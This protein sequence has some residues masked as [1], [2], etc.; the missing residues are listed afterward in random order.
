MAKQKRFLSAKFSVDFRFNRHNVKSW[1]FYNS[2]FYSS[3]RLKLF[4]STKALSTAEDKKKELSDDIK[5]LHILY[6]KDLY[7]DRIAPVIP[8]DPNLILDSCS[9]ISDAKEKAEFLKKWRSKGGIYII[10]YKHNPLIYYIGRTTLFNRRFNNHIKAET[11][12]KFHLFLN[13]VGLE[14]FKFSILEVCSPDEQ[15]IR[16]NFYLPKF[17]PILNSTFSSSFSESAIYANL[18]D[19]LMSLKSVTLPLERNNQPVS[20]FVYCIDENSINPKYVKYNSMA[21]V[22]K[23]EE[24]SYN[25]LLLFRDTNVPFRN[26]LYLTRP[27]I[28]FEST[29]NKI[30]DNLKEVKWY[31]NT[32]QTVWAYHAQT[33]KLVKGS[34]FSSKTLASRELGISRNVIN[35]FIGTAKPEG[36]KGTY[37]FS[38]PLEDKEIEKFLMTSE[39]ISLG[40][41]LEV[42]AYESKTLN[43]INNKPFSSISAAAKYFC[44]DYRTISRHLDTKVVTYKQNFS[45]YLFKKE[46]SLD[47]KAELLKS[48]SKLSSYARVE[49]WVYRRDQYGKM[50]LLPNQPFKT[51]REALRI[52]HMHNTVINKYIDTNKE[53]KGLYLYSS[54][55]N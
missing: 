19:K 37:L 22:I 20:V 6:I 55:L 48:T 1:S 34:P 16:E 4:Y 25:T 46:I 29:F 52:L 5:T 54:S 18:T 36:V 42:W 38:R 49:I 9:N 3:R 39:S 27:I 31:D 2:R 35:Y 7:K 21:E 30:K 26:K 43:L 15:G 8:F 12:S 47:L 24:I 11:S 33:L 10:E 32:A 23:K 51:K 40:N 28:D 13:L 50:N 53:Y 14:Y 17:L 44:V 45:V 41:K